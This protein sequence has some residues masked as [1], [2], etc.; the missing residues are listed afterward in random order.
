MNK[1]PIPVLAASIVLFP[2]IMLI[3]A[4]GGGGGG[5]PS[6]SANS[7]VISTACT[8]TMAATVN[9]V[10]TSSWNP[11]IV[12]ISANDIVKWDNGTGATH[13]V[14][15]T[16]TPANGTFNVS[17]PDGSSVCLKFTSAGTFN[18]RCA[19]H[20]VMTGSVTVN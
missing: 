17:L 4:C 8:G 13:T 1:Q 2:I 10:G 5:S 15:S 20:P 12:T 9:A 3:S 7:T 6:S 14:T 16:T 19:I 18:Y 11:G